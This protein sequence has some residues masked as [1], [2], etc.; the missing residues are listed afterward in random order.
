MRRLH[1]IRQILLLTVRQQ[2][3]NRAGFFFSLVFPLLLLFA[4]SAGQTGSGPVASVPV[5]L[6]DRDGGPVAQMIRTGLEESGHFRVVSGEEAELIR[7]L[8]D[9]SVRA[10]LVLPP[11]L[12]DQVAGGAGPGEVVLRWDPTSSASVATKGALEAAL[13]LL[14]V[15]HREP[16]LTVRARPLDATA[17]LGFFD[18]AMPSALVWML[19]NASILTTGPQIAYQCRAGT[20]RHMFST[21]LRMGSWLAGTVLGLQLLAFVQL[22]VLWGV[23]IAYLGAQ[24]PRNLPGTVVILMLSSAAGLGIGLIIATFAPSVQ[25]ANPLAVI[26]STGLGFLGQGVVASPL[27]EPLHAL[28]LAS[29]SFRMARA[30]QQVMMKGQPLAA[31][32]PDLGV[33][34]LTAA[35]GLTL[36]ALRLRRTVVDA[37]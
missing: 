27:P 7:R 13:Q 6:V 4:W 36:A 16:L 15:A 23:G 9:G 22:L 28:M 5:G 10:V 8:D 34:A 29:P 30:L 18:L 24:A 32:L 3:R 2:M 25:A 37:T 26:V 33:L 14:D 17:S 11:G 19:L 12:S 35:L 1:Q 20:L 31:V 21:P